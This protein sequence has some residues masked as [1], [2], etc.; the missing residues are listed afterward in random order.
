MASASNMG[1]HSA[2]SVNLL[3]VADPLDG[4]RR[5]CTSSARQSTIIQ[6]THHKLPAHC[7]RQH[8]SNSK[9]IRP[10]MG[11]SKTPV[12]QKSHQGSS[13]MPS[14]IEIELRS[15]CQ[16]KS[17]LGILLA[18][19]EYDSRL[20]GRALN[21]IGHTFPHYSLHDSTHSETILQRISNVLGTEAICHLSA[22]DLWLLLEAAYLHDIGMIVVDAARREELSSEEFIAHVKIM[23]DHN[24]PDLSKAAQRIHARHPR[25]T[26]N[27]ILDGQLDLILVYS[28]FVR[29]KHPA[30][31]YEAAINPNDRSLIPSPRTWLLPNRFW[32][33]IGTICKAHGEGR[34]Y[35][36]S[37]PHRESGIGSEVCHPRFV[38]SMLR[39]GDLLD[40][41][42]GRFCSTMNSTISNMPRLSKAH[43]QKHEGIRHFL[44]DKSRIE[45]T[46]VYQDMDAYL[47]S[48]KWFAWLKEELG[49]Q[50]LSWDQIA[51][52][53]KIGPLPSLGKIE[54]QLENQ[55]IYDKNTGPRFGIDREKVLEL[56]RGTNIYNG[57][58]D[59]LR[60]IIQNSI[61]ATLLRIS[62][63]LQSKRAS[64]PQ[65]IDLLRKM[66]VD[67][68]ILITLSKPQKV[69]SSKDLVSI[70]IKIADNGIGM[71]EEDVKHLT[72]LGSSGRNRYKRNLSE[73]LPEWARP[74]GTFGIGLHSIFEHCK[75]AVITTRHPEDSSSISIELEA[76]Q[77]G[78]DS[79]DPIIIVKRQRRLGTEFP[80]PPG[81]EILVTFLTAEFSYPHHSSLEDQ[82]RASKTKQAMW[83]YD[84]IFKDKFSFAHAAMQ[85]TIAN[86]ATDSLCPISISEDGQSF[87]L[88]GNEIDS[89]D[90]VFHSG[91]N[92][93]LRFLDASTRVRH[94]RSMIK[95]RGAEV[96]HEK[97]YVVPLLSMDVDIHFG[98]ARDILN[99][100][101]NSLTALGRKLLIEKSKE[102]LPHCLEQWLPN[103]RARSAPE[104][105]L[106]VLSLFAAIYGPESIAGNEWRDA[107]ARHMYFNDASPTVTFGQIADATEVIVS[108]AYDNDPIASSRETAKFFANGDRI[109]LR[110]LSPYTGDSDVIC[111]FL[112]KQFSSKA[113]DLETREAP[114][115]GLCPIYRF[116]RDANQ[117]EVSKGALAHFLEHRTMLESRQKIGSSIIFGRRGILPC[118][119]KY[120]ALSITDRTRIFGNSH[121]DFS[122]IKMPT[123]ANPFT[124]DRQS[125]IHIEHPESYIQWLA[126]CTGANTQDIAVSFLCFVEDADAMMTEKWAGQKKYDT[127]DVRAKVESA[128]IGHKN[129][130]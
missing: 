56:V 81:T 47:E 1:E 60:E 14:A 99:I 118:A 53:A 116:S 38:A 92:V 40:L 15:R 39:L 9:S 32:H 122:M 29:R 48:E 17:E 85:D 70:S 69:T 16:S 45:V 57:P 71:R 50:L 34:D 128:F 42:S 97:S 82:E 94:R 124:G 46:G 36:M 66:L 130:W 77:S 61:D 98:S 33:I 114:P 43:R 3:L 20:L 59:A 96:Q 117:V 103:L 74:S 115:G 64:P 19:W 31:A 73:W 25:N 52:S 95:Y 113:L 23:T 109:N 104:E 87:R 8:C 79:T 62:Y 89:C 80:T 108:F 119:S 91:T 102:S 110:G 67:Y 127:K 93:E 65:S 68:P 27:E 83:S 22:T 2:C 84:Y 125:G 111:S 58:Q 106:A 88:A 35:V 75:K 112:T 120:K 76:R 90:R 10:P 5:A 7:H 86:M 107:E 126:E 72:R 21:T 78:S 105:Q 41:D 55:I 24:D 101:R 63:E 4:E 37:L 44:V 100:S 121:S 28:E 30:R 13:N 18:Q 26:P 54:A 123:M 11:Q 51:P 12:K 6:T 129:R 49:E